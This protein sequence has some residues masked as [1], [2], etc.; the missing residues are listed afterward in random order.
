MKV[1]LISDLHGNV[2][3]L[4]AVFREIDAMG[5]D[6]TICLGDIVDLGPEPSRTIA[7]LRERDI[8]CLQGNHDPFQSGPIVPVAVWEWTLHVL[9]PDDLDWLRAL[10]G[11]LDYEFEG[12][13][14]LCVHG[15]PR[16]FDE[17]IIPA[18]SDAALSEMVTGE[19]FDVLVCGHTHVQLA[20]QLGGRWIVNAGSVAMPFVEPLVNP[21]APS[22]LPWAE[23]AVLDL[24]SGRVE[25]DLRRV[26][27][28][29]DDYFDRVR[30]STMPD[31]DGW[32]A[33]W[34]PR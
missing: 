19:E 14:L 32:I 27:Y 29:V 15:S 10:P 4:D 22:I 20:R 21:G 30:K 7:M 1:A 11:R 6:R 24:Q 5:V 2:P 18:T 33:A 34:R 28:D 13:R 12:V 3:A 9:G 25:V 26:D 17:M 16:S 31:P 8:D 23:Y